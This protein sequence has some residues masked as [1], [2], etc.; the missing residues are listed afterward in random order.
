MDIPYR[1]PINYIYFPYDTHNYEESFV[2][3]AMFMIACSVIYLS[4]FIPWWRQQIETFSALLALGAGNSPVT[5]E[6]P[7]KGQ[8]YGALMFSLICV[9]INAWV[10]NCEAGDLRHHRAHYDVTV[11]QHCNHKSNCKRLKTDQTK[12][13]Q[14]IIHILPFL[15]SYELSILTIVDCNN[16]TALEHVGN[17]QQRH[18]FIHHAFSAFCV[19]NCVFV[20]FSCMT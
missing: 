13:S 8:W 10:N 7:Y 11:M 16:R 15:A 2:Y 3:T 14:K 6:F 17:H 19:L 5:G 12:N 4:N 9:W 1:I 18:S 20:G